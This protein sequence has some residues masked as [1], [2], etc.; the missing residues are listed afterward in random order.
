[1]YPTMEEVEA[2]DR[3]T[4]CRWYRFLPSPG[5]IA[6]G[7]SIAQS[8]NFE[9]AVIREGKIMDRIVARHKE[10]GGFSPEISKALETC[11]AWTL[12]PWLEAEQKLSPNDKKIGRKASENLDLP[13]AARRAIYLG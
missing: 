1:M 12:S 10:L 13:F 8:P 5:W 4:L 7:P 3:Y 2:A 9:E 6:I 11:K